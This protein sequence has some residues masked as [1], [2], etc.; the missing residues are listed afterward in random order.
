MT[1]S[2]FN[3][4]KFVAYFLSLLV[5]ASILIIALFTQTFGWP[6]VTFMTAGI[7]AISVMT[8]RYTVGQAALDKFIESG[9]AFL[10]IKSKD[11]E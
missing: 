9:K 5:I 6:M 10:K 1:K 2:N 3:S 7:L 4:K 8:I 11:E